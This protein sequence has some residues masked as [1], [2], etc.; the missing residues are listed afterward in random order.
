MALL[1]LLYEALFL[2]LFERSA[3]GGFSNGQ[4]VRRL[5]ER[6]AQ[7]SV[8]VSIEAGPQLNIDLRRWAAQ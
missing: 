8:V 4:Q 1:C 2:Q 3:N 5:G 7:L 6:E